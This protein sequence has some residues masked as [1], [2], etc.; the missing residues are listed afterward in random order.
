MKK[1]V[2]I[3]ASLLLL[4]CSD[5]DFN[6]CRCEDAQVIE[7]R[8]NYEIRV[9]SACNSDLNGL[10]SIPTSRTDLTLETCLSP[11]DLSRFFKL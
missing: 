5:D 8:P 9:F 1:L 11:E 6:G 10:Y 3:L 2:L 7:L 4:S